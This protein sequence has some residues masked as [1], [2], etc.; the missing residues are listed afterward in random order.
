V[1]NSS[2][3][4]IT[5][6]WSTTNAAGS[7]GVAGVVLTIVPNNGGGSGFVNTSNLAVTTTAGQNLAVTRTLVGLA[8]RRYQENMVI[9]RGMAGDAENVE[10]PNS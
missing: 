3:L 1:V 8:G 7:Y 10:W 2:F 4:N 5:S 6:T 9:V